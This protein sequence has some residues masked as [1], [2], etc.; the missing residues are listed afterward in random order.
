MDQSLLKTRPNHPRK[1]SRGLPRS[2]TAL[3]KK[4]FWWKPP[5]EALKDPI[6]FVAQ[7]MTYGN[8]EETRATLRHF[9]EET[10][11]A[12]LAHPPPGVFD[13]RSWAYWHSVFDVR[14][15]PKL[16]RRRLP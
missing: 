11:R 15:P 9:G 8:W 5:A 13:Q 6:R 2:L 1:R 10:F 16:P 14:P 4:I 3:A 7:A 12:A